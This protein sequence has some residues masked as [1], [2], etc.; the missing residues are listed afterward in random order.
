MSKLFSAGTIASF[1]AVIVV[2]CDQLSKRY[3][4]PD[5]ILVSN[6]GISFG[7]GSGFSSTIVAGV[8]SCL[9]VG[10]VWWQRKY[11][12][13][14]PVATGLFLGGAI[15]NIFDR[16]IQEGTV[17]DWIRIPGTQL[18][19]NVADW[20]IFIGWCMFLYCALRRKKTV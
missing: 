2:V 16:V 13:R 9:L 5:A 1:F 11:L 12:F 19:N 20:A 4:A 14:H 3:L 17:R 7:L 18:Y 10:I 15:S 8:L 6:Q